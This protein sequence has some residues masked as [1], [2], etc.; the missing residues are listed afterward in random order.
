MA[1]RITMGMHWGDYFRAT[2]HLSTIQHGAYLLLIGHYWEHGGLPDDETVLRRITGLDDPKMWR[3]HK[4]V[5]QAF[6]HHGWRHTR[7]DKELARVGFKRTPPNLSIL[8]GGKSD[9]EK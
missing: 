4:P 7:L 2:R 5:L 3:R 1:K 8:K 6:F 9:E